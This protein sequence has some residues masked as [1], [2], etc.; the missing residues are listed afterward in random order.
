MSL[1]LIPSH[2][3]IRVTSIPFKRSCSTVVHGVPVGEDH[4]LKSAIYFVSVIAST[5]YLPVEPTPGQ[6]W[7]VRGLKTVRTLDHGSHKTREHAY[8]NP[9]VFDLY[10]PDTGESFT[11]FIG[12]DKAF[13]GI[14]ESKARQLWSRFGTHIHTMLSE[15]KAEHLN[16][17]QEI[18]SDK[19][20]NALFSGYEKY[21]NLRHNLWMSKAK[22]PHSVQHRILKHHKLGTVE[23][24]QE[25]P[26]ELIN[27]GLTFKEIDAILN[28]THGHAWEAERYP[29]SVYVPA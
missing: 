14:G 25:N 16:A 13:I 18:L 7:K 24:I 5:E 23:A 22:I 12:E 8:E 27:F 28:A 15:G 21:K 11:K 9:D 29:K 20:I 10:M 4:S 3:I 26:F 6:L 17:L 1:E 19:S 2:E